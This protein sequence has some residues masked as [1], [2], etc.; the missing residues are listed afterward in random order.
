[1]GK[2]SEKIRAS[3]LE[4]VVLLAV[5]MVVG[6]V[7]MLSD[8][9]KAQTKIENIEAEQARQRVAVEQ[10]PVI[11]NDIEHIKETLDDLKAQNTDVLEAIKAIE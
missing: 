8:L 1:M 7:V 4:M 9:G 6:G 10:I 5:A 2:G 11:Q 3:V